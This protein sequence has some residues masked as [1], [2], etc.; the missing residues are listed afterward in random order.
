MVSRSNA[1]T[2]ARPVKAAART[3]VVVAVAMMLTVAA[4]AGVTTGPADAATRLQTS[5]IAPDALVDQIYRDLL[6]R[7]ADARGLNFWATE[8]SSGTAPAE[9]VEAFIDSR[10]VGGAYEPTIRLYRAAFLRAPDPGGLA[11][12]VKTLRSGTDVDA[13]ADVFATSTEFRNRY[14]SL[15]NAQFVNRIY[16]NVLGRAADESGAA[17][18][19]ARL[20]GGMK[21]GEMLIAFAE[22]T[23]NIRRT[24]VSARLSLLWVTL[25][26]TI[27]TDAQTDAWA[28]RPATTPTIDLIDE[29]LA[30]D[31]Y[32]TRL[33]RLF[34][35]KHPLTGQYG[36]SA[37]TRPALAIKIDNVDQA[38]PHIGLNR[39]DVVYEEMVEG[40]LT[41][42][43]G[44]YH[45]Q[46][47]PVV[48]PVRSVR[49]SDFDV[50]APYNRPLLAASGAN[51]GV[52]TALKA[53]PVVNVNALKVDEY[54]RASNRR[55]P[56]NLLTSPAG[57]WSH[58]PSDAG[59][60][61]VMFTTDAQPSVGAPRP[62]G[63][64]IE[65]GRA[66]VR[67]RWDGVAQVWRR[68]QNGTAHVDSTG[69]PI[70]AENVIVMVVNYTANAIDAQSPE[71]HTVGRL[72]AL[73][74]TNGT[75]IDGFWERNSATEPIRFVD[76]DGDPI[77]LRPGQ[78]WIE[79]APLYKTELK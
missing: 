16:R 18:W 25:L 2:D 72:R 71:A 61:P 5:Q 41:R 58:A 43:I 77:V 40:N 34:P 21:R 74:F 17:Y 30:S 59:P 7:P 27:P 68:S 10:E 46:T 13:V 73:V 23:E 53:A 70:G 31:A 50:L 22:S 26:Q 28:S 19:T 63:V 51:P 39:A 56:H 20:N 37:I 66:S 64:A 44:V 32:Q 1:T 4:S 49:V 57:L 78:T 75:W 38:R 69:R 9:V 47:P 55:I 35:V 12:W 48:G 33:G 42:L 45:S 14:G 76:G 3:A 54:W 65:F 29:V 6:G 11:Y 36:R 8:V 67:W 52:L 24:S 60:P 62:G 15:S 79:L